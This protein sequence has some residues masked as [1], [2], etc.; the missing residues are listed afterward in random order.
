MQST[1]TEYDEQGFEHAAG[2][3]DDDAF[4]RKVDEE[5]EEDDE[6]DAIE[7]EDDIEEEVDD[8]EVENSDTEEDIEQEE[9]QD[10]TPPVGVIV[11]PK[12]S[13]KYG[14]TRHYCRFHVAKTHTL[15]VFMEHLTGL[16]GGRKSERE[17]KQCA[18]DISKFLF[19]A[20]PGKHIMWQ[21]LLDPTA[22]KKY[23]DLLSNDGVGIEGQ[24]T[25]LERIGYAL[26]FLFLQTVIHDSQKTEIMEVQKRLKKWRIV[27]RKA[28]HGMQMRREQEAA[29]NPT[30]ITGVSKLTEDS[31]LE[32]M[33]ALVDNAAKGPLSLSDTS[34][35]VAFLLV[36]LMFTNSQ[37]PAPILNAKLKDF[38]SRR[39]QRDGGKTYVIMKVSKSV[40]IKQHS[41]VFLSKQVSS[42]K[43]FATHG[44]VNL[45]MT[46]R[47]AKILEGYVNHVRMAEEEEDSLFVTATGNKITNY[48]HYMRRVRIN[49]MQLL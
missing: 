17:A 12:L 11:R 44:P 15:Q 24:L 6:E 1:N 13:K 49:L 27:L 19:F 25:K 23:L 28:R 9:C 2:V 29:E 47:V 42:H 10:W 34:L 45:T 41:I 7:E 30:N 37:R 5:K 38:N 4:G 39:V 20:S 48:F 3:V 21:A 40:T 22:I 26:D 46:E 32:E 35:V 8:T 36:V 14:S 43:T 33:E 18:T 16:D 31:T